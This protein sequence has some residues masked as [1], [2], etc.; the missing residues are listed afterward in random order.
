MKS[1]AFSDFRALLDQ[2]DEVA[3][4][5][6]AKTLCESNGLV[7]FFKKGKSVYGAPESSRLTFAKLKQA[8]EEVPDGWKDEANFVAFDLG[9][10]MK[11]E[12]IQVMFG[13]KDLKG[14]KV[15]DQDQVEKELA[16]H[17][18]PGIEI[19]SL[20]DEENDDHPTAPEN[21]PSIQKVDEL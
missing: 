4:A 13:S 15:I 2:W 10:A 18:T 19:T 8:D 11:G 17:G 14:L 3:P 6:Q 16:K 12:K 7:L 1:P 21:Q 20:G 5:F 9:K